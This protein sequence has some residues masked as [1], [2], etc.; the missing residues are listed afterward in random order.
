MINIASENEAWLVTKKKHLT[1]LKAQSLYIQLAKVF[2][3]AFV[4]Y[5]FSLH[6]T[7][8]IITHFLFPWLIG[9][10]SYMPLHVN[11]GKNLEIILIT[12]SYIQ[13]LK[14]YIYKTSIW[15]FN[16]LAFNKKSWRKCWSNYY[17]TSNL[18][19][20][21]ESLLLSALQNL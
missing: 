21:R 3:K 5:Y 9:Y 11:L 18:S 10:K 6:R 14:L 19:K 13:G 2:H 16:H 8:I 12:I 7:A 1:Y 4:K 17:S 15:N 20:V